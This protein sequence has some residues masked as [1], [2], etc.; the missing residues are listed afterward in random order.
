MD[1]IRSMS[2]WG[3]GIPEILIIASMEMRA[4]QRV[5][6]HFKTAR[7]GITPEMDAGQ[8]AGHA[9]GVRQL[10]LEVQGS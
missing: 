5:I 10:Y 1:P 2:L 6:V 3:R 7:E 8:R 4:V 9:L